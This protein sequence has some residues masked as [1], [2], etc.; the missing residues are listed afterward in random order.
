MKPKLV[1]K[2]GSNIKRQ[3]QTDKKAFIAE[4]NV[5]KM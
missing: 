5:I 3:S 1:K 4:Q 2:V